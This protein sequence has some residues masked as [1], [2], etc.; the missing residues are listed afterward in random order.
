MQIR[1]T[2][3]R[4]GLVSVILHWSMALAVL[5]L[6]A[7]GYWMVGL[8]YFHEWYRQGPHIHRSVGVLL[9]IA[10]IV[11]LIWRLANP[12][13]RSLPNHQRW[14]VVTAH[15]VHWLFYGLL[16]VAMVSGYLISTADGRSIHVFD[17]FQVPSI[18]GRQPGL[19]DTAGTVHEWSTWAIVALVA[20]HAAGALK[21]HLWDKD[22]TLRRM[23]G[24]GR[25]R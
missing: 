18:T 22:E 17:W 19:E 6:F 20:V 16:F 13:P 12:R 23:L 11:R 2:L 14:E 25:K 1:N 9:F 7:L 24:L 3:E 10:L 8:N 5:A 21:H 15:A 4:Y